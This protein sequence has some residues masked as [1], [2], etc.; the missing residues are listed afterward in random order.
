[1]NPIVED[2][3]MH[4]GMPRRSGRYPWGSGDNPYQ[5][6]GDFLSRVEELKSQ[7]LSETEIA[8]SMGLTTTQYRTQK[9]LAKD[10]RRALDVARARS[11]REDGKSLN[12]IAAIMGFSND[13]SVRS[14]LNENSEARMNQARK[15]ADFLKEQI[16]KKG[17]IDVGTG[18]ER[19]LGISKEKLNQALYILESEGYPVYGGGVPQVTNPGKQTNIKVI[20]P[21]GTEHKEIYNFENVHSLSDYVSHD[22]GETYDPKYVY[23]KSMDSS[24]IQIRYA[25]DGGTQKD[26][27]VEIRRGVDDLSLGESHYAQ[28]RILVDGTHYIKGM[29]IY[30]DDLPDGVDIVFNTNKKTGT[31]MLGPKNDTVLKPIGKDPDNPFGSL[32][33]DGIVDPDDPTSKK[34]GQSYYYDKDGKKQLSLINKRAEEGDW[35]EWSDHLPSQFLSKQSMTLIKK[36]LG[37]AT[38]DK[39]AEFDEI[40]SLTNPTVKKALLKSFAD[41]CDSAAIH[42]QAAALPRQKYQVILPI[43]SMKDNE[44]YAPNYRNGEQVALI[45][46]PHGGTFEIPVLTVNNKQADAKRILGNAMDAVGINS[47]VA[48]RLSGADFDGD[49]VMVIPTGGKVKITSTRAL[50]GLEGFDPKLEYGGKPE[51]SFKPMRNTQTEMGKISNLITDMTLRGA[52]EDELARAVR[53]SMVVIDAEKHRL[54]YKQSEIDNGIASLKKKYQGNYDEDGRYHEGAATLISRA[55]SETSV[56][57]RKGSPIINPETGEQTYKEVYEEYT[58]K[59]GR[60][61]VRTQASTKMAETKDAFTLVSD[62]DTPQ[63]RAYATYANEMKSLANRA[64][65][66][67]LGTGKI[68]Y[69]ASAKETY[70]EEVDHLMAQLN[71]A[72]RNAPRERQAQVIANATVAAKK[73]ENPDMTRSEIK[74][75]SQQALTAARTTV[76]ASRE[77]ISISDRE[78]EA[79]QAG[80]ISENRL[81]QI[82]NNVDI[83]TLRQRATPRSTTVLSTAK[84]N[85]IASMSAS[86]YS[87][88]EIA[89]AL[90]VSTSTVNKYLK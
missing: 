3:L 81:T 12:E 14:L 5:H 27:V 36:Q 78:W 77:T 39:Q 24:R 8:K 7:G 30:S 15:T 71:V 56:L 53:H 21:P 31:P 55:K 52:S 88:A 11:L 80:A 45:R 35:G 50:E 73:Q 4:Y 44:V 33:K 66:E 9:S 54:D 62:A 41:D 28:V 72:L 57:K 42:L 90:G 83:D 34:G 85:K 38:A 87:T 6:S 19:E 23:P 79:I 13:S 51:G 67:M 37:L 47:K 86:G 58:D 25:E 75:A 68:A 59:N 70:Q 40:C 65:K 84:V 26:G 43:T 46:F 29:A 17:M 49:T 82:I 69:S 10:E 74:K 16:E 89:E 2:M 1:M 61:R 76:G 64:R 20:C 18:V 32:I 63:E 48:E 60:T 22:G